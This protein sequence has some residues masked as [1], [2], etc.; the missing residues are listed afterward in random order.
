MFYLFYSKHETKLKKSIPFV[1]I[2]LQIHL[3]KKD[4]VIGSTFQVLLY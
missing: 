1:S 3:S 2:V 4:T